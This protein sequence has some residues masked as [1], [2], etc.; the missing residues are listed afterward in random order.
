[1]ALN[2][3]VALVTG[4]RQGLGRAIALGLAKA[5]ADVLIADRVYQRRS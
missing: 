5:G 2:G 4:A 3:K 1:M